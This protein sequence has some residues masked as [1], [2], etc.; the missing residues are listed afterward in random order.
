MTKTRNI[1]RR[2]GREKCQIWFKD[3]VECDTQAG[4]VGVL[5]SWVMGI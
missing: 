1:G 2:F 5:V 4:L 3:P